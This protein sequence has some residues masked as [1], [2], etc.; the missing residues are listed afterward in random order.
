MSM[1]DTTPGRAPSLHTHYEALTP[2]GCLYTDDL[3]NAL[4][5]VRQAGKGKLTEIV[6]SRRLIPVPVKAVPGRGRGVAL[7]LVTAG[8]AVSSASVEGDRTV[9]LPTRLAAQ[10]K[11]A[12][13]AG[14][15]ARRTAR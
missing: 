12:K 14:A 3:S 7:S 4:R 1:T 5:Y 11:P 10:K 13:R 6:E 2:V 8:L 9:Q 15:K